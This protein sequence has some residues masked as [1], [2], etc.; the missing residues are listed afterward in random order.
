VLSCSRRRVPKPATCSPSFASVGGNLGVNLAF[1]DVTCILGLSQTITHD[2]NTFGH[3]PLCHEPEHSSKVTFY[4]Y[5]G[6]GNATCQAMTNGPPSS[7]C[8][9]P[10]F[11]E[12]I[13]F[14]HVQRR[15]RRKYCHVSTFSWMARTLPACGCH[16]LKF[17]AR[18]LA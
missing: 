1:I 6:T 11:E 10:H 15:N 3:V 13:T 4:E 2:L 14:G 16:V 5:S 9:R 7:V 18:A 12:M 17:R 8:M